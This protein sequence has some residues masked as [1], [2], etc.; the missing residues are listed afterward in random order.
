MLDCDVVKAELQDYFDGELSKDEKGQITNHLK[1]CQ[2]CHHHAFLFYSMFNLL[3]SF[4]ETQ[5]EQEYWDSVTR[6]VLQK[7][8]PENTSP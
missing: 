4:P 5:P 1:R 7:I 2:S 6:Q 3:H 8:P